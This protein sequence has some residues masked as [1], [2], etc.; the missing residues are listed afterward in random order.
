MTI[1]NY[2]YEF[3]AGGSLAADDPSYVEREADEAL[4]RAIKDRKF[5]YVFNCRQMGKSSLRVRTETRLRSQD[6]CCATIDLSAFGVEEVSAAQWYRT[7]IGEL[8]RRLGDLLSPQVLDRWL[9]EQR[10]VAPIYRLERFVEDVVLACITDQPIVIFVDE[11]DTV[12]SLTFPANDFFAWIR[13]CYNRRADEPIYRRLTFVLLGVTTPS[14]LIQDVTRTPFNIGQAI[15]LTPLAL[16]RATPKLAAGLA[17][18]V[19]DPSQVLAE[20]FEWTGGQP[21]LTQRLCKE[22]HEAAMETESQPW[23][24]AGEESAMVT[25]LVEQRI[26]EHWEAQDDQD[27][28]KTIRK[29]LLQREQLASRLLG[30]YENILQGAVVPKRNIADHRELRLAGLVVSRN[31]HLQ[32]FNRIYAQIFDAVW[33]QQMLASLR[34]YAEDFH[35]WTV[36]NFIDESY[37]LQGQDLIDAEAWSKDKSL[38]ALDDRYLRESQALENRKVRLAL[39]QMATQLNENIEERQAKIQEIE[40]QRQELE[41]QNQESQKKL[42]RRSVWATGLLIASVIGGGL[43]LGTYSQLGSAQAELQAAREETQRAI[44]EAQ[45]ADQQL[46][47]S[48]QRLQENETRLEELEEAEKTAQA[49][50]QAAEQQRQQA[51]RQQLEAVAQARKANAEAEAAQVE[52]GEA[53]KVSTLTRREAE[54]YQQVKQLELDGVAVRSIGIRTP[55]G[56][57]ASATALSMSISTLTEELIEICRQLGKDDCDHKLLA[58]EPAKALKALVNRTRHQI[59]LQ[60][61][62]GEVNHAVFSPNGELI[63]TASKD[64]TARVWALDGNEVTILKGHEDEVV[65]AVF[66]PNGERIVTASKDGTARVWALDGNEVTVLRGHS[67][68]VHHISSGERIV[69]ASKDGTAQVWSFNGSSIN[70]LRGHG[71]DVVHAD[72][73]PNGER[74]VT[75]SWDGTA[76]VWSLEGNEAIEVATL[77]SHED[78]VVHA[79]FSPDGKRIVTASRDGTARVWLLDSNEVTEVAALGSHE[80]AV[81]HADFSPDG[82]RIVTASRDGTARVWS[83][84]DN[85][86]TEV[87]TLQGHSAWVVHADFSPDGENIVTASKDGTARI[88]SID[89]ISVVNLEGP[90]SEVAHAAF[91]PSDQHIVTVYKDGTAR[92]WSSNGISVANLGGLNEVVRAVFSPNGERIVTVLRNGT[93]QIWS[94]DGNEVATLQRHDK[95]VDYV[96]FSPAGQHVVTVSSRDGT[97]RIWSLDGNEVTTLEGHEALVVYAAFS[98]DGRHIVTTSLDNTARV[99]SL[100]G[101][102]VAT[103][104]GHEALVVYAAFSP[105]SEHI[106]TTSW[107]NT[108]RV[109]SLDG[110]EVA[111]L[112]DHE[113]PVVHAAFSPSSERIVTASK[114]GTARMW[115]LDGNVTA[116]FLHNNEV[117][118][119]AFSP[120]GEVIVTASWDNTAR[121]WSLDGTEVA[122]LKSHT[123]DVVHA[124]FSYDGE[125]IITASKDGMAKVWPLAGIYYRQLVGES[126][127][128]GETVY[129]YLGQSCRWLRSYL[130]L[131]WNQYRWADLREGCAAYW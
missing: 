125:H 2:D 131:E 23:I 78:A 71:N 101:N 14:Q 103:L 41:S 113:R 50:A 10:E 5:A 94:V 122:T 35:A 66:S 97:A 58:Q 22:V 116:I 42:Q 109:W 13:S 86:A 27:H 119:A 75:A 59:P 47:E 105:D 52:K 129:T 25:R 100:D 87:A 117:A 51:E 6:Y 108:A 7:L 64:G 95:E 30:E 82:K 115:S 130:E 114:D 39:E 127:L 45:G 81:V 73:S 70:T 91:S 1:P 65:R 40:I 104:E 111:T 56:A 49:T 8:N 83:L 121:V 9:E 26:I 19:A 128:S 77:G 12:L 72:F 112:E 44:D 80:D 36:S 31:N 33:V 74:I 98:P 79:D 99:W 55:I 110:T 34:P 76:R 16:A 43:A 90:N 85:E 38:S 124:A 120:G 24:Q 102:E 61:H 62:R 92:L 123:E 17:G 88:W 3:Q 32:V 20:I 18:W 84:D 28:L 126:L 107:D 46:T 93:V 68:D 15:E 53:Q 89:D 54:I 11:I 63:V 57:L 37:L 118:H 60:S 48:Q 96:A 106:V 67:Q 21:Y 69:T 4:Y 29:R